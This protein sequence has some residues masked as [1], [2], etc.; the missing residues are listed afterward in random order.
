MVLIR[1][2]TRDAGFSHANPYIP[3]VGFGL[4][5]D[6]SGNF[7]F[8]GLATD[9]SGDLVDSWT[10]DSLPEQYGYDHDGDW[11]DQP[12]TEN[13]VPRMGIN[14]VTIGL[15]EYYELNVDG[16]TKTTMDFPI[17]FGFE[18]QQVRFI[19]NTEKTGNQFGGT[20]N[21]RF[22]FD[23]MAVQ[24]QDDVFSDDFTYVDS[25][26]DALTDHDDDDVG[27]SS[28]GQWFKVWDADC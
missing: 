14:R 18:P 15:V 24:N 10:S 8:F 12:G 2:P 9:E 17:G 3:S 22:R 23:D 13:D 28:K 1:P 27:S 11:G 7:K 21:V 5:I 26:A 19:Y 20:P 4:S 16:D 6:A 25:Y